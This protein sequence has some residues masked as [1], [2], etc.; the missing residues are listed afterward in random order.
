MKTCFWDLETSHLKA[1]FGHILCA[2]IKPREKT[3]IMIR[4]EN[5][6]SSDDRDVVRRTRDTLNE[7][8]ILVGFYTLGFDL[9]ELNSRLMKWGMKPLDHK[10]H[11][12][13]FH[14]CKK[15]FNLHRRSLFAVC[16]FL[17]IPDKGHVVPE[18]WVEAA[19]DGNRTALNRIVQ[20]CRDDVSVLEHVLERVK[21]NIRGIT[22]R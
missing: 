15:T 16:D 7:F 20:H 6:P 14:I 11:I 1:N 8:D 19:Y 18:D 12:D 22:Y 9:K 2:G 4:R 5:L 21:W 17:H 10:L 3:P 13:L